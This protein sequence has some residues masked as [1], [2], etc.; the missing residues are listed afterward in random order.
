MMRV[1]PAKID[2]QTRHNP[3]NSMEA[4]SLPPRPR[5][6]F[7]G[8][9]VSKADSQDAPRQNAVSRHDPGK[10]EPS[11]PLQVSSARLE[12]PK[13]ATIDRCAFMAKMEN[14]LTAHLLP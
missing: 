10:K 8:E 6:S 13:A 9:Q 4:D 11:L 1:H 14:D 2:A 7:I 12:G 5:P 3:Q